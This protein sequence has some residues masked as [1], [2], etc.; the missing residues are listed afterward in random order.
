MKLGSFC[1]F[2]LALSAQSVPVSI[3]TA[4]QPWKSGSWKQVELSEELDP[5][6]A[7][8][9]VCDMWDRHWCRGA[10]E[11]V[12]ELAPKLAKVLAAA[13]QRGVLIIHAPSDTV[14]FYKDT[15]QRRAV[16]AIPAVA[17]PAPLALADPP[18]PI[19]DSDGGCDTG[20]KFYKAWTRQHPAIPIDAADLISDNGAEVYSALKARGIQHLLVSGVHTNMCILNRTFAIKQMS[21][22]GVRTILLRDLTDSMYDPADRPR[23][24]HDQGT[25]LVIE[26]IEKHWCP[27]MLSSDLL[28]ALA[29]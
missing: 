17:P 5:R 20:D 23:V 14:G 21:K 29:K 4:V 13:R 24:S 9:I 2:A 16:L 8:I 19:D 22:W 18:L 26:H 28:R 25:K 6:R 11:R 7:A 3:R 27:T 10:T 15:P 12:N 1:I